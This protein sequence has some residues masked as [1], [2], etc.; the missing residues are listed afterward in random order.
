MPSAIGK[1]EYQLYV[2]PSS[3]FALTIYTLDEG[4]IIQY[5]LNNGT[6]TLFIWY[7]ISRAGICVNDL[8]FLAHND[9][10]DGM[11]SYSSYNDPE[12]VNGYFKNNGTYVQGYY[13]TTPDNT[14]DN[15]YSHKGNINPFTGEK[16][17]KQ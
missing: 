14:K 15:N 16:G 5:S 11:Y 12:Y 2:A 10:N 3:G 8:W 7:F 13:R 1:S 9:V 4:K 17:Y 6:Y